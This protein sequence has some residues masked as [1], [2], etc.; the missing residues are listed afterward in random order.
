M[1]RRTSYSDA[2]R[3]FNQVMKHLNTASN[4]PKRSPELANTLLSAL[5]DVLRA[6]LVLTGHGYP[7]YSDITNLAALLLESGVIDKKTFSEVVNAYLGLK[8]IV[9]I[10]ED[11]IVSVIRKLIYIASS[12][13]PYLDQQLSLFRY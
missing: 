7:S 13:D 2:L 4:T 6:L 8:G 11:Y 5:A 3:L 10:S 1:R 12:L 9:K